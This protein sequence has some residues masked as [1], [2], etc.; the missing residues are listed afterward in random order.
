[1]SVIALTGTE[2]TGTVVTDTVPG[3][4][5]PSLVAVIVAEPTAAAV[6]SP[7]PFTAATPVLLLAHVMARPTSVLPLA[8]V[9]VAT[10]PTV[11]PTVTVTELGARLTDATGSGDGA[12]IVTAAESCLFELPARISTVP[13]ALPCT[14]PSVLTVA[15]PASEL[16]QL[17]AGGTL[18]WDMTMLA[19]NR[20][21]SPTSTEA[22]L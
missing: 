10:S 6:T 4:L 19:L 20:R 5:C 8:S 16:F 21:L 17:R 15:T 22:V 2:A 14:T 1:M 11:P 9:S 13:K 12:V 18:P 3:P 7:L